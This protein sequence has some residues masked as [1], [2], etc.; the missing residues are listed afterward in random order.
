MATGGWTTRQR[1]YEKA[2]AAALTAG[3]VGM[4]TYG[5]MPKPGSIYSRSG[6][7]AETTLAEIETGPKVTLQA[8]SAP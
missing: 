8:I 7:L 3:T 1:S 2:R 4:L 6:N 5:G